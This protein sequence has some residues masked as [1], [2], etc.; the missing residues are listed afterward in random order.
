MSGI[1]NAATRSLVTE[2]SF[3]DNI[4]A[5]LPDIIG[6]TVG[7]AIGGQIIQ[8]REAISGTTL[9]PFER[10]TRFGGKELGTVGN[11][12]GYEGTYNA[13]IT[14][15]QAAPGTGH[16]RNGATAGTFFA[17]F[18]QDLSASTPTGRVRPPAP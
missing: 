17:D 14:E 10:H 6:G 5:A 8:R 2:T 7:G 3:G 18:G 13:S 16:F 11:N 4:L 12:G 9:S 1:V 15:R